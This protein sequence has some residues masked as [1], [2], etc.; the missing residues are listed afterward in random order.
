MKV[1]FARGDGD[2]PEADQGS[3]TTRDSFP[4]FPKGHP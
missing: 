4:V 2:N 3:E 1:C